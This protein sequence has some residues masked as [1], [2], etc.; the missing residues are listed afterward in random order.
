MFWEALR[1][2][3]DEIMA[4]LKAHADKDSVI[5]SYSIHYTKLYDFSQLLNI[6]EDEQQHRRRRA[7]MDAY[8]PARPGS[9]AHALAR[10]REAGVKPDALRAWLA[11]AQVSPVLTAH[12]TEVQRQSVLDCE[13]EIARLIALPQDAARDAA[14]E[15]EVP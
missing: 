2:I 13:R 1:G 14:L 7:H 6:A 3:D 9:F 11:R 15:R 10:V 8:A 5:T 4:R 12:P